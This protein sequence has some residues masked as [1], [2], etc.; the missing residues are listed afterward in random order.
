MGDV[1]LV[2][3]RTRIDQPLQAESKTIAERLRAARIAA[4]KTQQEVAGERFSKGSISAI[5]RGKMTPSVQALD[6]LAGQL[7]KFH[8]KRWG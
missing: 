5:E 8:T 1:V 4:K 3:G 7:P 2:C 6:Y